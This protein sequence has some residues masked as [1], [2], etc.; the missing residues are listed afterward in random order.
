MVELESNTSIN[1]TKEEVNPEPA[2]C[3]LELLF[4]IEEYLVKRARGNKLRVK[5]I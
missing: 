1:L 3:L 2:L 4:N 5:T